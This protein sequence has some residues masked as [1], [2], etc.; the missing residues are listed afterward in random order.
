M[1]KRHYR[2]PMPLRPSPPRT[3]LNGPPNVSGVFPPDPVG[4]VGPNHYVA[5]GNL[6][7]PIYSKAGI[8]FSDR[9]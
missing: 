3:S 1:L 5:M 9:R 7:F 2:L 6:S 4:N 8:R